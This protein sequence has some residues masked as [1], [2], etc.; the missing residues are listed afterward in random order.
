MTVCICLALVTEIIFHELFSN[1]LQCKICGILVYS[2]IHIYY[3]QSNIAGQP[4]QGSETE[5]IRGNVGGQSQV[6][7]QAQSEQASAGQTFQSSPQVGQIPLTAAAVP[8]PSFHM[9]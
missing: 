8:V 9:V 7:N 2:I 3:L 5:G 1:L 6:G 4:P